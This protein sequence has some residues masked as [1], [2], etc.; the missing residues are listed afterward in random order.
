M[1]QALDRFKL[2]AKTRLTGIHH[3]NDMLGFLNPHA[4]LQSESHNGFTNALKSTYDEEVNVLELAVEIDR[5]KRLVR[6]SETTFDEHPTSGRWAEAAGTAIG[7]RGLQFVFS[8]VGD[9]DGFRAKRA[10]ADCC[11]NILTAKKSICRNLE[12]AAEEVQ[13]KKRH[14]RRKT[15]YCK[16]GF[17]LAP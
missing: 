7:N 10:T 6:S 2:E 3:L 16:N 4:L 15:K 8:G 1:L 14:C 12:S 17:Y 9:W 5:F 11:D 13:R